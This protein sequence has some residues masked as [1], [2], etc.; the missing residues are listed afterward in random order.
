M[1][2]ELL[3]KLIERGAV[4]G[5]F[6]LTIRDHRN[7]QSGIQ[8]AFGSA[9]KA[10]PKVILGEGFKIP[11]TKGGKDLEQ[12]FGMSSYYSPKTRLSVY[13]QTG[14]G[15]GIVLQGAPL[16]RT[17]RELVANIGKAGYRL[18]A[19]PATHW[20]RAYVLEPL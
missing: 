12:L 11:P 15:G 14:G 13:K 17:L 18:R 2:V 16:K 9:T 7:S 10:F 20:S 19:I 5:P 3:K 6:Y 1:P 8:I 4:E